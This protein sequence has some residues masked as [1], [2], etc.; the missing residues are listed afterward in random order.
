MNN[1][2]SNIA[3]PTLLTIKNRPRGGFL[4]KIIK[5]MDIADLG[6]GA[7]NSRVVTRATVGRYY[8]A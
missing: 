7:K 3:D 5:I 1:R 6:R 8:E 2:D 4:D